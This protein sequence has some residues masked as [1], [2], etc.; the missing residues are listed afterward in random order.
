EGVRRG[1][2]RRDAQARCPRLRVA[3]SD[4]ARDQRLFEPVIARVEELAPGVQPIRPGLCAL[5]ARGPARYYG[6]E[7]HAARVLLTAL[8]ELGLAFARAGVGDGPFTA[9]QAAL[10]APPGGVRSAPAG[11]AAAF[12]A[13]LPVTALDAVAT[14]LARDSRQENGGPA[15][16]LGRLG[17]RTLGEF[18]ALDADSVLGRFGPLGARLHD[19][20]R[21][22]DSR[23]VRPRAP[24][25][26]LAREI[27]FEPPLELVDQVAFAVRVT[28]EEFVAALGAEGLVCTELRV[29]L[30][31]ERGEGSERVWLHPGS[32]DAAGVVDRVRWQVQALAERTSE[33]AVA[34]IARVRVEPAA[35]DAASH[36]QPAIFGAGADERVHHVLSRVQ[37]MLGHRGVLVPAIGGGRWLAER[38]ALVPWG[39]RVVLATER[40]RPWPGRLPAPLPGTVFPA[41]PTAEVRDAAGRPVVVDERGGLSAVPAVLALRQAQGP[42]QREIEAWAG[43]WPVSERG[44]DAARARR[45]HRFQLVDT[46][47][48]AWLVV[49]EAGAWTVE[50]VYD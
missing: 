50:G 42:R 13:P 10:A 5:R 4:P 2:R 7:E 36:H 22:R 46:E 35:V 37:A 30:D 14:G 34:G 40:S 16:L 32:F 45:A 29:V 31:Q 39:D 19:L 26:E 8:A 41:P 48:V 1:Q 44:W 20:A 17:V 43:P 23:P 47:Q 24:P 33:P 6:G 21:G 11:A 27:A 12:L 49:H 18:A 3:A 15:E 25:P 28:A 38:Q 9:E